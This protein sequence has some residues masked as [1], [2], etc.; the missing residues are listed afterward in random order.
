MT[1]KSTEKAK[2]VKYNDAL[3]NLLKKTPFKLLK[4][5]S[6]LLPVKKSFLNIA[7]IEEYV[8]GNQRSKLLFHNFDKG[9]PGIAWPIILIVSLVVLKYPGEVILCGHTHGGQVNLPWL[10]NIHF[11]GKSAI[12]SGLVRMQDKWIYTNRGVAALCIPLVRGA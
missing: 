8:T 11:D 2:A 10:W 5:E 9:Y 1:H 4:N 6:C 7:G 12:Q 3:E